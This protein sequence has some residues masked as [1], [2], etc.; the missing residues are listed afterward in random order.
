M[1]RFKRIIDALMI[2]L[3][4][5][6]MAFQVTGEQAHEWIGIVMVMLVIVHQI[7]NKKWYV[8]LFKC[9]YNLYRIFST[10]INVLLLISFLFTAI[11]GMSMSNHAV[12]FLYGFI[13]VNNAR[14]MHLA[15]SYWSFILMGIHLGMHISIMINKIP[16]NIKIILAIVMIIV[17]GYGFN[18]F[19][20]SGISNYILFKSHFAF[21][22][23]EKNF[24]LVYIENLSMLS[25]F[26]FIGHNI[27]KIVQNIN[28]KEIIQERIIYI[29]VVFIIGLLANQLINT[30]ETNLSSS[31]N[32]AILKNI[33]TNINDFD[34]DVNINEI[35]AD[36][37]SASEYNGI[38]TKIRYN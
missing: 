29:L 27:T 20:K 34:V 9:K 22:D 2:V 37:L 16:K 18:L 36:L 17:S 15:F 4:M 24:V 23:Y 38:D 11:S 30:K 26:A 32:S 25:L 7:L 13:N 31:W 35:S 28:K 12:P 1:N 5:C 33:S 19:I 21:L 6:L 8:V 14:V 10:I 3:L